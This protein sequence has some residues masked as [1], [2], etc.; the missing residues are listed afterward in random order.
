MRVGPF[1]F[2]FYSGDGTEPPHVHVGRDE[3]EAKFWLDPTRLE[4]SQ[5]FRRKELNRIRRVVEHHREQ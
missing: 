1:R 5:G 3:C 2:F 4:W